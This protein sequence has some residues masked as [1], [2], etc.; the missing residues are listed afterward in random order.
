[1]ARIAMN[2]PVVLITG[3][4]TGTGRAAAL[5]FARCGARVVISGRDETA[6]AS[7][8]A[9]LRERGTETEVVYADVRSED[10]TQTLVDSTVA[11]FGRLDVAVNSDEAEGRTGHVDEQTPPT[12]ASVFDTNVLGTI[13][14]LKHEL[15][16]MLPQGSDGIIN[17]SSTLSSRG[18]VGAFMYVASKHAVEGV[19]KAATLEAAAHEVRVS[20]IAFGPIETGMLDRFAGSAQRK[21]ALIGGIPLRRVGIPQEVANTELAGSHFHCWSDYRRERRQDSHARKG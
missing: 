15:R 4:L 19:T 10:E 21:E 8:V 17:I 5:A 9:E 1:M 16:V 14:A 13:L 2:S 20:A 7:F 18:A 12:N 6:S 3:S 11:R